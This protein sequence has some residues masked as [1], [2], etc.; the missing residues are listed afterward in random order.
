[1][2]RVI[3]WAALLAGVGAGIGLGIA[4]L[5]HPLYQ[6]RA[7]VLAQ[8]GAAPDGTRD[9]YTVLGSPSLLQRAVKRLGATHRTS[10]PLSYA[11]PTGGM[12]QGDGGA[13]LAIRVLSPDPNVAANLA[14]AVVDE[15]NATAA[16]ANNTVANG[17]RDDLAHKAAD[18]KAV[19]DRIQGDIAK[20]QEQSGQ[21]SVDATIQ[22]VAQYQA[23]LTQ[24]SDSDANQ[25]S[26][27]KQQLT[28][29]RAKFQSLDPTVSSSQV[30][31]PN[32]TLS[33][34][35]DKLQ[36]LQAQRVD[37][38]GTFTTTSKTVGDVDAKIQALQSQIATEK[39]KALTVQRK[40]TQP[41]PL[42]EQLAQKIANDEAEVASLQASVGEVAKAQQRQKVAARGLPADQ[43]RMLDLQRELELAT[44]KYKT[45]RAQADGLATNGAAAHLP[46]LASVL[47]AE[48]E[49]SPVWPDV[50]LMAGIGALAGLLIGLI[51][52][53]G[54]VTG[55]REEPYTEGALQG[56]GGPALGHGISAP[57]LPG[58]RHADI[59][60]L[61]LPGAAPAEAY[62]YMV[63]SMLAA[64]NGDART[65]LFTG[66]SSDNL[67]SE[68]AAQFA[69]A[70]SQTG[71]RTLLADCNLRHKTLT[72]AFGFDGKSGISDMLGCTML[73]TPGSDLVLE[74]HH[75]ELLFLP[76]GSEES[77]GLGSYQNLQINGLLSDMFEKAEVKVLNAP[78]CALTSDAPRLARYADSVCLVAS[79]ADRQRGLVAKASDILRRSGAK[80]V[81]VLVIDKDDS[82]ESFLG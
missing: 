40:E 9:V 52:G 25:L 65:I 21:I 80:E 41:N 28:S 7:S 1:M 14:N 72:E 18:S 61:A 2:L 42:R 16:K 46:V 19:V 35:L 81:E 66:V 15:Y 69:I 45:I 67:C 71:T 6:G 11:L 5:T 29:E 82:K 22:Q 57:P 43:A 73:P 48:P 4:K 39:L 10:T 13:A 38:L 50:N 37:L 20:Q 77:E 63:F 59:S 55:Q 70:V 51:V 56:H 68:A 34:D 58:R 79:K 12:V 78:A 62:R 17:Q 3:V 8:S 27:L 53:I 36:K 44:A 33:A 23:T 60:A 74:T 24:Q 49:Q 76:S 31:L 75:P 47:P 54:I 26:A 32:P 30:E 64:A